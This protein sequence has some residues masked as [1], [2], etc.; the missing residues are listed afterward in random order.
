MEDVRDLTPVHLDALCEVSNIGAGHAATALS[1]L[2]NRGIM[3]SVP[4][5]TVA[6]IEEVPE[7]V[8]DPEQPVA[9]VLMQMLG[10]LT[11]RTLWLL[12][13]D[14]AGLLCDL[15]LKRSAGA[16][17]DLGVLE[18]STLK[19]AANIIGGAYMNALADFMKMMLLPSVPSLQIDLAGAVLTTTYVSFGQN[20]DH[21]LCVETNFQFEGE[22]RN[23]TGHFLLLPDMA[24]L[25]AIFGA[26]RVT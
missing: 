17:T 14:A 18:Q 11:G 16:T 8:G 15:A 10:D 13:T 24:S 3:I 12:T 21:V 19:E 9:A 20:R 1:Q 6:S 25:Q 2:T 7:L 23:L 26:I 5:V 4:R 22:S